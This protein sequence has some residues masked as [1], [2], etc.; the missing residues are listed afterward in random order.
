MNYIIKPALTLFITATVTVAALSIAYNYTLD[1]IER[2]KR[3]T[4]ETAMRI[5][6]P[7]ASEYREIQTEKTGSIAAVYEG[8]FTHEA[9]Y[10]SDLVGYVVKLTP[11]GY[12]GKIDLIV[13]FSISDELIT[14]M[15]V[16]RHTETPGLGALA[17]K[18]NFYSQFSSL[19]IVPLSVVRTSP[20]E[21]EIQAITSSTITTKAIT[22]A[23]NEAVNWYLNIGAQISEFEDDEENDFIIHYFLGD[24]E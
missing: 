14:G 1:P 7:R 10:G 12:S 13:G 23:V 6:L 20:G 16:L 19:N 17:V 15:R 24:E 2:Q 9:L 5:V 8:H 11:E 4:Q 21:N 22:N 18:E 3:K